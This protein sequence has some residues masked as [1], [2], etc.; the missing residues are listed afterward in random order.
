MDLVDKK[1][2]YHKEA[3]ALWC[4]ECLT[5]IAQAEL[6]TK[7]LRQHLII[8]ITKQLMGRFLQLPLLVQN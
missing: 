1:Y 6:E 5:S 8:L 4:N 2:C 7:K 3:P